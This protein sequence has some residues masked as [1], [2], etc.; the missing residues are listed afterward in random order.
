MTQIIK[1]TGL[2]FLLSSTFIISG[3]ATKQE[4][5]FNKDVNGKCISRMKDR[6]EIHTKPYQ[7]KITP[8]VGSRQEDAKVIMN[9]GKVL[10]IW[11]APYKNKGTFVSGHDN[12]VIAKK[13][14]F[15][16]GESVPQRNWKSIKTPIN[17][18]PFIF[19]DADLDKSNTLESKEIVKYNNNVYKQ[20]NDKQVALDRLNESSIYDK[21]IKEFLKTK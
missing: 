19:R 6:R 14:D 16:M 17:S 7:L 18:I 10:K 20:E 8:I 15:I 3:C 1:T 21:E 2:L 13:A 5:C 12:F 4:N 9:M 11:I